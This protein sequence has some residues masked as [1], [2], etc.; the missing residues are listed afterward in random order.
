MIIRGF[1]DLIIRFTRWINIMLV[2]V[3]MIVDW[4]L[5]AISWIVVVMVVA[6]FMMVVCMFVVSSWICLFVVFKTKTCFLIVV[7][8]IKNTFCNL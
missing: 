6:G 8:I 3:D 5:A 4:M 7:W 2:N 1:P